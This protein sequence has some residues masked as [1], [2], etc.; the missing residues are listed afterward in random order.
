MGYKI[1]KQSLI[2]ELGLMHVK[3]W[4]LLQSTSNLGK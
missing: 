1:S 4:A 2:Q 3:W